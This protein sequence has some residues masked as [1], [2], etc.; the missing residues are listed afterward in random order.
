MHRTG[1][2]SVAAVLQQLTSQYIER[3]RRSRRAANADTSTSRRPQVA[4]LGL[5]FRVRSRETGY[6]DGE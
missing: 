2:H 4:A 3:R 5:I 1:G 6:K